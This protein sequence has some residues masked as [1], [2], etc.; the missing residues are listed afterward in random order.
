MIVIMDVY[1]CGFCDSHFAVENGKV[2]I[3]CP[4]CTCEITNT[5]TDKIKQIEVEVCDTSQRIALNM[6]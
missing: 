2:E 4:V 6:R 1:E 5:E 3:C